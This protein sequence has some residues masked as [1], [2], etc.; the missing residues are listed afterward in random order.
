MSKIHDQSL[1][2]HILKQELK[3]GMNYITEYS[4]LKTLTNKRKTSIARGV[5]KKLNPSRGW[6]IEYNLQLQKTKV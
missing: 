6:G 2:Q 4:C 3:W 5:R 1:K